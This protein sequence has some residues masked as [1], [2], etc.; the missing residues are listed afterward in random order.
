MNYLQPA[1]YE[2]YGLETTTALSWV[3]TASAIIDAHCQRTTL[4]IS[5][6]TERMRTENGNRP[7][8][9]TYLPLNPVA[10]AT[11]P[12]VSAQA[13]YATPRRGEVD[14]EAIVWDA[15]IAFGISG[16]WV[17]INVPD[18]DVFLDTG[19]VTLPINALGWTFTEVEF[20]YT[21]G[22]EPFPDV[23]KVACAQL[24]KN[25]QA[26]PALNVKRNVLPDRMQLMYFSNSLL[27][28]TVR[29]LLAPYVA[30]R[31]G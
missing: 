7:V 2:I 6:Y 8:R 26:T 9:L 20:V 3:T 13:R 21:A 27:D 1:E 29:S 5:T 23:V 10:P 14:Y 28:E 4:A 24:V 17:T 11:T 31:V 12:I 19:E 25:A 30:R 22:L 16:T 18:L 15:A